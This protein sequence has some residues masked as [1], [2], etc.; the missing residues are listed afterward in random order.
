MKFGRIIRVF[1]VTIVTLMA[2]V[3]VS[4]PAVMAQ[5]A[6][7]QHGESL[8]GCPFMGTAAVCPMNLVDHVGHW[9]QFLAASLPGILLVSFGIVLLGSMLAPAAVVRQRWR[10][11]LRCRTNHPLPFF[12]DYV[13]RALAAG[14]LHP[15]ADPAIVS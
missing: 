2:L 1:V 14:L 6:S 12:G 7:H 11:A 4:G 15:K 13:R 9:R 3:S 10:L 5:M 8:A